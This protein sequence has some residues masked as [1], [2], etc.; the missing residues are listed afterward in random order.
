M[1]SHP[2]LGVE[3]NKAISTALAALICNSMQTRPQRTFSR[4]GSTMEATFAGDQKEKHI[5]RSFCD[6][7]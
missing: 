6:P 2:P 5:T 7:M 4:G 1:I 3:I